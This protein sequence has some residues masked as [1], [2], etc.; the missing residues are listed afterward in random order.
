MKRERQVNRE[1][2]EH[3]PPEPLEQQ[4]YKEAATVTDDESAPLKGPPQETGTMV[5]HD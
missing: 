2:V 5:P 4:S 3:I 1:R